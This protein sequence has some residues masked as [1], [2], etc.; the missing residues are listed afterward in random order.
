[1][2]TVTHRWN[3]SNRMLAS[4]AVGALALGSMA[5]GANAQTRLN[6]GLTNVGGSIA[7]MDDNTLIYSPIGGGSTWLCDEPLTPGWGAKKIANGVV[8]GVPAWDAPR[9]RFAFPTG[10]ANAEIGFLTYQPVTGAWTY[11]KMATS[12]PVSTAGPLAVEGWSGRVFFTSAAN[13]CV[14]IAGPGIGPGTAITTTKAAS[15]PAYDRFDPA[16]CTL[17][18]RGQDQRL[19]RTRY[20]GGA[21]GTQQCGSAANVRGVPAMNAKS[22]VVFRDTSNRIASTWWNGSMWETAAWNQVTNVTDDVVVGTWSGLVYYRGSDAN[23]WRCSY[24]NGQFV[25]QAITTAANAYARTLAVNSKDQ[26]FYRGTD[27]SI[28]RR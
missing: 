14:Y 6:P 23:I 18:F 21:W 16:N 1:M 28:W 24:T 13:G 4:V 3:R 19:H 26:V 10:N 5:A 15:N 25:S 20:A 22:S 17:F 9:Q 12:T 11:S 27:N 8:F 7:L 2:K